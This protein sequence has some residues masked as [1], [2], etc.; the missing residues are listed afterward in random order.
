MSSAQD[1]LEQLVILTAQRLN[2][3][4]DLTEEEL[5]RTINEL[6]QNSVGKVE[7]AEQL[8]NAVLTGVATVYIAGGVEI[9]VQRAPEIATGIVDQSPEDGA[10]KGG[11]ML[12]QQS[13]DEE[14]LGDPLGLNTEKFRRIIEQVDIAEELDVWLNEQGY[15][16]RPSLTPRP[17]GAT[18][19]AA[20]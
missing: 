16:P 20:G 17:G 7:T 19:P 13:R 9:V 4:H 10:Q 6:H 12:D 14:T 8:Y 11:S 2:P 3:Q 18:T 1:K 15:V 5:N